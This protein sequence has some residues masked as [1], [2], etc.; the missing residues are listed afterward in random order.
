MYFIFHVF[1]IMCVYLLGV[2][3]TVYVLLVE[4]QL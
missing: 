3:L 4:Y 2:G 1:N